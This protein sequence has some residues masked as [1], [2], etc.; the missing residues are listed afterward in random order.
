MKW[1]VALVF[2][3]LAVLAAV[4]LFGRL[5]PSR[6]GPAAG[7]LLDP[8]PGGAGA[9]TAAAA[10]DD[11]PLLDLPA[12]DPMLGDIAEAAGFMPEGVWGPG[13]TEEWI[14]FER[15]SGDMLFPSVPMR[16]EAAIWR[17]YRMVAT[18]AEADVAALG[19][20]MLSSTSAFV[21]ATGAIWM[22][23]KNR[24]LAPAILDQ[25]IGDAE[26]FVPLTVLGWMLDS[27]LAQAAGQFESK[28][29][30]AA[31]G[32]QEAAIA[33]LTEEPLNSMAGRAALWLAERSDRTADEKRELDSQVLADESAEFGVRWQ[34][35]LLLRGR[36]DFAEYQQLVA[37]HMSPLPPVS[38]EAPDP[39]AADAPEWEPPTAFESAMGLLNQRTAGPVEVM[40]QRPVLTKDDADLFFAEESALMLENV[41]LWVEAVTDY[42]AAEARTGFADALARYVA[43]LP[44]DELPANQAL[45]LRRIQSRMP[46]LK[47]MEREGAPE[48]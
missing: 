1:K 19:Y 47:Q 25:L 8:A 46:V 30:T 10:E 21:R 7:A 38:L 12:P 28:W 41:A 14:E 15:L 18:N 37:G 26:A 31:D 5:K 24:T 9:E 17:A 23:E 43:E 42:G 3:F 48:E 29:K 2:G 45:A 22:L 39:E 36:M 40:G 32:A 35:A 34:A 6:T 13:L 44:V 16:L 4:F 27:G 20:K 11:V 33:A